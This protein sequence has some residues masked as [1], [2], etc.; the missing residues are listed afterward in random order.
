MGILFCTTDSR[1]WN[2]GLGLGRRVKRKKYHVQ[3]EWEKKVGKGCGLLLRRRRGIGVGGGG[4]GLEIFFLLLLRQ[5]PRLHETGLRKGGRGRHIL[6]AEKWGGKTGLLHRARYLRVGS[7]LMWETVVAL[8]TCEMGEN[9]FCCWHLLPVLYFA[10]F[11]RR[12]DL[13][14]GVRGECSIIV[15]GGG[16]GV[17]RL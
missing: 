17:P 16:V 7:F 14:T 10:F 13:F 9:L 11:D 3:V 15:K 2:H 4:E 6:P 8:A 1:N 12:H 5:C